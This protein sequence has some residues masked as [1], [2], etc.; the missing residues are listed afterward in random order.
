M[1]KHE[2]FRDIFW[3]LISCGASIIGKTTMLTKLLYLNITREYNSGSVQRQCSWVLVLVRV[4][5][6]V[7]ARVHV[8]TCML[9]LAVRSTV[10]VTTYAKTFYPFT[11][12]TFRHSAVT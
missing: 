9:Q 6:R 1:N 8:L 11:N 2:K 7:R 4:R 5:V 10:H 12:A 3:F